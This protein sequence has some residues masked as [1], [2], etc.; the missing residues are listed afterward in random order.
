MTSKEEYGFEKISTF[1]SQIAFDYLL[2]TIFSALYAKE[3]QKNILN[4]KK[5]QELFRHNLL[6]DESLKIDD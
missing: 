4:L 2:N 5:K 3:Y 6:S 1:S